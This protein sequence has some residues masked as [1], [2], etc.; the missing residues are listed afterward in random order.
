ESRHVLP[1][2]A[3]H[4]GPRTASGEGRTSDCGSAAL[5]NPIRSALPWK[6][7]PAIPARSPDSL[8]PPGRGEARGRMNGPTDAHFPPFWPPKRRIVLLYYPVG[9][10]AVAPPRFGA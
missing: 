5:N 2:P 1:Q 10:A 8:P 7:N 9:G 4:S 6:R 3:H